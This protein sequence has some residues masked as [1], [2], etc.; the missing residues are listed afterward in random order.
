[1]NVSGKQLTVKMAD[2][3]AAKEL[4]AMLAGKDLTINMTGNSFEQY[5]S[6]GKSLT[7]ND[8]FITAQ[9]GDVLLYNSNTLCVFYDTNSYSYTR[10]GTI[11]NA[12][13]AELRNLL[14]SGNKTI[15]L[16][17]SSFGE[18]PNKGVADVVGMYRLLIL[19]A[20]GAALALVAFIVLRKRAESAR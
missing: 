17:K 13:K 12:T 9:A 14:S 10:I 3:A 20:G 1:M 18:V 6:L 5:G 2:T 8:T 7:T 19:V 15:T 4:D 16:S 11:Q